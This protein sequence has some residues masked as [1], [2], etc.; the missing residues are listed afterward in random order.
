MTDN[1]TSAKNGATMTRTND[2]TKAADEGTRVAE[3]RAVLTELH[4]LFDFEEP[5]SDD[6]PLAFD[7]W[8]AL[9]E[10]F[11]KAYAALQKAKA[12]PA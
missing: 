4:C 7:D 12:E 2:M 8:S 10:A 3:M 6:K 5:A 11:A 1:P 9:N